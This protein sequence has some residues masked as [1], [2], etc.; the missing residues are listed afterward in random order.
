MSRDFLHYESVAM[1]DATPEIRGRMEKK[2]TLKKLPASLSVCVA[3]CEGRTAL[4]LRGVQ[5][6][7]TNVNEARRTITGGHLS[8]DRLGQDIR[9]L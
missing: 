9:A 4:G 8:R 5:P 2:T 1:A 7:Q 3:V 6:F